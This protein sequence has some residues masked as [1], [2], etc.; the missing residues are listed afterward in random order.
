LVNS[1]LPFILYGGDYNPDQWPQEIIEKDMHLL[2]SANI[3]IVTLP[4][5]SW[6]LLQPDEYT[7]NFEWLDNILNLL[8]ENNIYVCLATSTAAQPAWMSRKY[9]EMLPVDFHG[10]KRKHGGR[11]KFCPNSTKYRELSVKLARKL[12]ERY[13]DY[14]NLALW[15]VGNEYDN[16]CYCDHCQEE[17]RKWLKSRYKTIDNLNN[18]WNMNFWG[19]TVYSW[20][21]IVVPSALNEMWDGPGKT[22]TTFQG[23]A[24]DYNRFMSDSIL[25]CYIGEYNAIKEITPDIKITT[26]F[27]GTFK[28]LDYFKWADYIDIISWDNYPSYGDSPSNVAMSHD[29]MRGL[30]SG[31]PFMLIE[32]SPSQANWQPY[33]SVKRP[34]E[35]KLQS[36]QALAHGADSVMFFQMR[37]SIGACE[38]Y[39]AAVISHAGSENTRTFKECAEL[40]TELTALGDSIIDSKYNSKV[41]IIFDWDNWWAVEF[42][43]GPS[44]ELKYLPQIQKYYAGFH[45]KNIPVDFV[46]PTDDFSKY[47]III[48]PVL[49]ML[50][51]TVAD[52]IKKFVSNGGTFLTTFFSG[53]VDENDRVKIGGYPSEL[54]DLL[55]LWVEELDALPPEINNSIQMNSTLEGFSSEYNCNMLFDIINLEGAD[56]LGTYG[57]DFYKGRPVLTCNKFGNGEAYYIASNPETKF[58]DDLVNYFDT[59]HSLS[60]DF[61]NQPGIEITKRSKDDKNIFFILNHNN[62]EKILNLKN[63]TF[64]NLITKE[65]ITHKLI[66]NSRDVVILKEVN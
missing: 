40:G 29:L 50:K 25:G 60:L 30:K 31:E 23:M 47:D 26:N 45:N 35:M 13:K 42:S 37:Q 65:K 7:Y 2:K 1:N 14:S 59:K 48:A 12:A 44:I 8:K 6:A 54:R 51:D 36:Y 66:L 56:V 27:M 9:P 21:E 11:V 20:D 18:A 4:V 16:Y 15:H 52:N 46:K 55:G 28:P 32:Q 58:V 62:E 38:K 22:C 24:L 10:S 19:H 43:S 3:N 53:Y 49:Y 57:S 39:H 61:E 63:K 33:N 5:F 34:G 41:G 64:I 17:F